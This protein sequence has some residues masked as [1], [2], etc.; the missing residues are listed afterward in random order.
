MS[1]I[2]RLVSIAPLI[3]LILLSIVGLSGCSGKPT[4]LIDDNAEQDSV[5]EPVDTVTVLSDDEKIDSVRATLKGYHIVGVTDDGDTKHLFYYK[6]HTIFAYCTG[7][8]GAVS[9]DM[10]AKILDAAVN[11]KT[12]HVNVITDPEP[13]QRFSMK[14]LYDVFYVETINDDDGKL[15]CSLNWEEVGSGHG[16]EFVSNKNKI[17]ITNITGQTFDNDG[18]LDYI[19]EEDVVELF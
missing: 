1:I 11:P 15:F 8:Q 17:N 9:A 5:Y 3:T 16:I 4:S 10:Y 6:G 2:A 14:V 19:T 7:Q 13:D 12:N 18:N